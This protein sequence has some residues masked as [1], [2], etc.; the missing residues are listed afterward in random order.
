MKKL[1][2]ALVCIL[3]L[4]ITVSAGAQDR[5]ENYWEKLIRRQQLDRIERKLDRIER[6]QE[7]AE[8]KRAKTGRPPKPYEPIPLIPAK[9]F[10]AWKG[11]N[12]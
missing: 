3:F 1:F 2:F 12:Q 7:E 6:Q 8:Y 11:L 9:P 5:E 10:Q 4:S